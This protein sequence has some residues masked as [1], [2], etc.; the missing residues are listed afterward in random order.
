[1]RKEEITSRPSTQP[2]PPSTPMVTPAFLRMLAIRQ[3]V[4]VLPLV[5]ATAMTFSRRLGSPANAW[6]SRP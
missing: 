2:S 5:P 3:L 1:M 6:Q 4:V